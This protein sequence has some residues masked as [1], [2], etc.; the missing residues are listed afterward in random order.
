MAIS[1][2]EDILA[3]YDRLLAH[4]GFESLEPMRL[5]LPL[6]FRE[7][8]LSGCWLNTS[9][10]TLCISRYPTHAE[11]CDRPLLSIVST[12]ADRLHFD[13]K[14]PT[15]TGPISRGRTEWSNCPLE[16]GLA[17]FDRLYARFLA[18]HDAPPA[19]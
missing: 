10:Q 17:E 9:H 14:I 8:D 7:R 18:A 13:L 4:P 6:L 1:T 16:S 15:L 3:F 19:G 11:R 2:R 12:A 5:F